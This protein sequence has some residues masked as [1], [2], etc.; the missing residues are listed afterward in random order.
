MPVKLLEERKSSKQ[1]CDSLPR[2]N[3]WSV[4]PAFPGGMGPEHWPYARETSLVTRGAACGSRGQAAAG[5]RVD[6]HS[7]IHSI[8]SFSSLPCVF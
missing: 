6:I 8:H 1:D 4:L 2:A 5:K 3:A 7:F